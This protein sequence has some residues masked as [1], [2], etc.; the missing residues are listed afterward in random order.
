MSNHFIKLYSVLL[1][2]A[3]ISH[4]EIQPNKYCIH[5]IDDK[6]DGF[7]LF[8]SGFL[9]SNQD[10]TMEICKETYP[11]DYQMLTDWINKIN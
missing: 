4:I 9:K 3:K 6:V 1:N 7:F 8:T 10:K 11:T 5:I 2:T